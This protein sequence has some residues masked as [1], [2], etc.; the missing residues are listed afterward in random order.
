MASTS[1]IRR[2][3][4]S[5]QETQK[6]THAMYLIS[7]AKMRK[8][9]A[10]LDEV[11]PYFD[12]LNHEITRVFTVDETV[13][14]RYF[15]AYGNDSEYGEGTLGCLVITA[16]KGLAGAYNH[17]VLKEAQR[18]YEEHPDTEFFVIGE[19]G[20]RWFTQKK[21]PM[22]DSFRYT[23]QNPSTYRAQQIARDLLDRFASGEIDRLCVIYTDSKGMSEVVRQPQLLPLRRQSL[24][25]KTGES[26]PEPTLEAVLDKRVR[27][28][29]SG[30][31][32]SALVDSFC[33]E[34]SARMAAMSA[35]NDNA[36]ELLGDLSKQ[37]NRARQ[38]A[39]T[40]EITE[41]SAGARAQKNKKSREADQS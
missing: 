7:S 41:I 23:A 15:T 39:I 27:Y 28:Y 19:Y 21:L 30:Y 13:D 20:R 4:S 5:V 22:A 26:Q 1:E 24:S 32:Y 2:R 10:E 29:I 33:S 17:N 40:Q 18:I 16:D 12:V 14:S 3:I 6:I 37:F 31:I 35:A 11:R 8:A 34:Q 9:R 36:E 38:A 25:V